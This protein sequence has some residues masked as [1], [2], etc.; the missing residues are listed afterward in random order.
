[1]E[2]A[3]GI[4]ITGTEEFINN[5]RTH[6]NTI[7]ETLSGEL[8]LNEIS[9]SGHTITISEHPPGNGSWRP[10]NSDARFQN[11]DGTPGAGT[12]GTVRYD[13]NQTT[14]YDGSRP[15][16]NTTPDT[17]LFHELAHAS[18]GTRGM[19]ETGTGANPSVAG[20]GGGTVNNR[21]L[22]AVGLSG[23][24]TGEWTENDYRWET[25]QAEREW[26]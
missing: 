19:Q 25:G 14:M 16:M 1:V 2:F 11:A 17:I 12:N 6:L 18:Q 13:P 4:S 7:N 24:G 26:Y 20:G 22:Q 10:A 21:E 9:N 15:W 23:H 8:L 3:S 5:A